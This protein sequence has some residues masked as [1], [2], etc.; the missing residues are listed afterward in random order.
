ML[1]ERQAIERLKVLKDKNHI[2]YSKNISSTKESTDR[3]KRWITFWRKNIELYIYYVMQLRSFPYQ[4][5][6]YSVMNDST[7]YVEV[8]TRGASK[9]FKAIAY[10][11]AMSL[12]YPGFKTIVGSVTKSQAEQ[13][14][15]ETFRGEICGKF[16]PYMKWLVQNGYITWKEIDKGYEVTFWNGST[17][18][19]CPVID[20][21]R[22]A[23]GNLLII[24]ECRLI[25]KTNVDSIMVPMHTQRQ[26]IYKTRP[27]YVMRRDL[28]EPVQIIYITSNRFANEWFNTLYNRTFQSYF[29]DKLNKH[30]VFNA[31]IFLAIKYGLKSKEWLIAQKNGMDELNY[32]MELLNETCGEADNA[33]FT[34]EQFQKNQVLR[35]S[36]VPPNTQQFM[37]CSIKNRKKKS[38]EIRTIYI[39]FAFAS[40]FKG[41]SE[42]DT[43]S[44]GC[45]AIVRKDS[46]FLRYNEHMETYGGSQSELVLRRIRELYF[47]YDANYII[48]DLRNGGELMYLELTKEYIHPER[49]YDRWNSHGFTVAVEKEYHTVSEGKLADLRAKTIDKQAIPC[50]IPITATPELNSMMWQDLSLRLRNEEIRLL[51]D[52]LE[53]QQLTLD[54]KEYLSLTSE[55]KA[56]QRLAY[57]QTALMINEAIN[58]S[59]EWRGGLL[60]LT[61]PNTGYKDRIVS[62]AYNNLIQTK[63][64]TK[65]EQSETNPT[66]IDWDSLILSI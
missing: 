10:A 59:Q 2:D 6:A 17:M 25:K 38:D 5:F 15:S 1:T 51:I 45:S 36:F 14:F 64:I 57:I 20:S 19:F 60:R 4:M 21:S 7:T 52:D 16:S 50:I 35:N 33:Y 23:H 24:E 63:I 49:P 58:L 31:D 61:E 26:P 34:L 37:N 42:N 54:D 40:S 62:Y 39:D 28:D 47:D 46:K 12:L 56:Q 18:L 8:S 43:T 44:I 11:S 65:M 9:T 29:K 27:E 41:G 30:R 13:D 48:L 53:Y 32:R 55:E 22:G 66:E 3:K